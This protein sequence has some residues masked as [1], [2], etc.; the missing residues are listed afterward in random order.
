MTPSEQREFNALQL[1]LDALS[2]DWN[3]HRD[4]E[5]EW[6]RFRDG[7]FLAAG[8]IGCLASLSVLLGWV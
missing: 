8:V 1:R 6:R 7:T 2:R 4:V 3:K 5:Q